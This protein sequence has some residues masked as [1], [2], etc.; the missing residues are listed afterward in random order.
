[1]E[2]ISIDS[3]H[4]CEWV[5]KSEVVYNTATMDH[6]EAKIKN[7][8]NVHSTRVLKLYGRVISNE[9]RFYPVIFIEFNST[10]RATIWIYVFSCRYAYL[11]AE[12]TKYK[13]N[14]MLYFCKRIQT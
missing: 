14:Q 7:L 6:R 3:A 4:K 8:E 13:S 12:I 5:S 11:C 10:D 9:D 2:F 1:M